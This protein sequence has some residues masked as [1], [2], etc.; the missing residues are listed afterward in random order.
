MK[1]LEQLQANLK[2]HLIISGGQPED[3]RLAV[4]LTY[5]YS[6]SF[7]RVIASWSEGWDHISVS[8]SHRCPTWQEMCFVKDFFFHP[9]ECVIQY[10]PP[11]EDYINTHKYC[12]HLW[13]P[14]KEKIPMPPKIL[15]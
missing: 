3:D 13:R 7:I 2:S 1:S 15:V 9:S 8:L 5:S 10:H 12:L 14:Q 6:S 11:E 4:Q